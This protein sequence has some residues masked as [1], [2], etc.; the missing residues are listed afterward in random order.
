MVEAHPAR[1]PLPFALAR[2]PHAPEAERRVLD[3]AR[4]HHLVSDPQAE[5]RLIGARLVD[6]AAHT[7]PDAQPARLVVYTRFVT[8]LFL[9]GEQRPTERGLRQDLV[10]RVEPV[11]RTGARHPGDGPAAGALAELLGEVY[12]AMGA[13][14]R[15][16]FV[17]ESLDTL[18]AVASGARAHAAAAVDVEEY[19]RRLRLDSGQFP[20]LLLDE[21]MAGGEPSAGADERLVDVRNAQADVVAW[22]R[23]YYTAGEDTRDTLV[24][25]VARAGHVGAER[26]RAE[27][28]RRIEDR[29][30]DFLTARRALS[31]HIDTCRPTVRASSAA[32][33]PAV[34][35]R[36]CVETM[37]HRMA[38]TEAHARE[39]ASADPA[40]VLAPAPRVEPGAAVRRASGRRPEPSER[41]LDLHTRPRGWDGG[42]ATH[43]WIG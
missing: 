36:R 14:W 42:A 25:V 27:V 33:T 40:F 34:A 8:W 18:R 41:L 6:L 4:R 12:P 31:S 17:A 7:H 30:A 3:W 32:P 9:V 13:V 29:V 23:E 19:V 16:R 2:N 35:L 20:C 28:A 22:L 39:T 38:A 21:Y 11:L 1:I 5:H 15:E 43:H 10:P 26:A 24:R 37:H